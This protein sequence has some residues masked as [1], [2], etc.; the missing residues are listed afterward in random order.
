MNNKILVVDDE[1]SIMNIIAYNLRKEGYE[2]ICAEDGEQALTLAFSQQPDLILLD[3][4]MPKIDG[5][6]VCKMVREKSDVPIIMLTARA[7]EVDKIIGLEIGADDYVTKPFSNRELAARVKANLRRVN[8]LKNPNKNINKNDPNKK[9]FGELAINFER[10]EV[11]KR[12]E[13][14][15]LTVREFELLKFLMINQ[16]QMFTREA[17][18]SKVWGYEYFG[19]L[20]AVDVTIRRLREKIEDDASK[21]RFILTKRGIGY[22]F[23]S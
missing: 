2:V 15:N 5:Y 7:D 13:L 16:N 18:L 6:D 9:Q 8:I 4:M 1:K 20:R 10:Y 11:F 19:D 23:V 14:I 12:G 22:Y 21:P 17:L 3:I